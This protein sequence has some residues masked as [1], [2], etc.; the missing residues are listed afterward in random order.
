L[1]VSQRIVTMPRSGRV[2]DLHDFGLDPEHVAGP[3]RSWP[4]DFPADADD[5]IAD[6]HV[7]IRQQ[8]HGDG[9]GVPAAGGETLEDGPACQGLVEMEG[10]RVELGSEGL[11]PI[12]AQRMAA[13]RETL[14]DPKVVEIEAA[15]L[16]GIDGFTHR[17]VPFGLGRPHP[18]AEAAGPRI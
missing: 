6:G 9:R 12:R 15:V 4:G 2:R 8:A 13:A 7:A 10:L 16:V 11:D 3:C 14:P 17:A 5:A 18:S 1:R